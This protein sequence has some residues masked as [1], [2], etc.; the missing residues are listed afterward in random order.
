MDQISWSLP[1]NVCTDLH[2]C[3]LP[4]HSVA[5]IRIFSIFEYQ[6][7]VFPCKILQ[8]LGHLR[9]EIVQDVNVGLDNANQFACWNKTG[10]VT[11]ST[12]WLSK[13]KRRFYDTDH[14]PRVQSAPFSRRYVFG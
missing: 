13:L 2:T 11:W 10:I 4:L 1:E 6:K 7:V 9:R 3:V 14:K 12:A 5:D 8:L